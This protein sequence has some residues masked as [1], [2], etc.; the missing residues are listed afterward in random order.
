MSIHLRPVVYAQQ[1]DYWEIHLIGCVAGI[2]LPQVAPFVEALPLNNWLGT[3]GIELVGATKR[4]QIAV[5]P[6]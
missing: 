1:P 6:Q 3:K 4:V 2:S 5:P